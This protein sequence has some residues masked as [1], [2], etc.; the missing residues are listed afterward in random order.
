MIS[1]NNSDRFYQWNCMK[2]D[3][4]TSSYRFWNEYSGSSTLIWQNVWQED[5]FPVDKKVSIQCS[6]LC[7]YVSTTFWSTSFLAQLD[8]RFAGNDFAEMLV[9]KVETFTSHFCSLAQSWRLFCV[10][11]SRLLAY[12]SVEICRQKEFL[13]FT[14]VS[15]L[16]VAIWWRFSFVRLDVSQWFLCCV[17]S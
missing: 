15:I 8:N 3:D 2:R 13:L 1:P 16:W 4:C 12:A 7:L 5:V 6:I 9:I 14:T 10:Y 17:T 11:W